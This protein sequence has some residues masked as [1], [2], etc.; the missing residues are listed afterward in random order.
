MRPTQGQSCNFRIFS[1]TVRDQAGSVPIRSDFLQFY[2]YNAHINASG[3]KNWPLNHA[4]H[5]GRRFRDLKK[6]HF[7]RPNFHT[8]ADMHFFSDDNSKKL[9][10]FWI[11]NFS[12]KSCNTAAPLS[13]VS[14]GSWDPLWPDIEF[15][16]LAVGLTF[17]DLQ[18]DQQLFFLIWPL[19]WNMTP[20]SSTFIWFKKKLRHDY[21]FVNYCLIDSVLSKYFIV[22][23][24][25]ALRSFFGIWGQISDIAKSR[26]IKPQNEALGES[27]SKK[28]VIGS[29]KVIKL[30]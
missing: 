18:N 26:K 16:H 20:Q 9:Q 23:W 29:K 2:E 22:I 19:K 7:L 27:F 8:F 3:S 21:F 28:L 15:E 30:F 1:Q 10:N 14:L 4:P 24:E 12:D 13:A 25:K 6:C 5:S 17:Y 11:L